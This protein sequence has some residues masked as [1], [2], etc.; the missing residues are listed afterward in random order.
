MEKIVGYT[1]EEWI[2]AFVDVLDGNSAW[3]EIQYNTGLP[4]EDCERL[5]IMFNAAVKHIYK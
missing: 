3:Y 4:Q 2:R 5:E 1:A